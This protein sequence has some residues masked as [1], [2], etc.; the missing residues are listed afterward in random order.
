MTIIA[1]VQARDGTRDARYVYT[2][3][4]VERGSAR[5]AGI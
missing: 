4:D 2:Y 5:A 1:R 3:A